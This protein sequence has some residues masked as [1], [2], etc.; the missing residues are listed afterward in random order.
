MK[1]VVLLMRKIS[2]FV[3]SMALLVGFA[4]PAM[5]AGNDQQKDLKKNEIKMDKELSIYQFDD[6]RIEKVKDYSKLSDQQKNKILLEMKFT[7]EDI[8]GMSSILKDQFLSIGGYKVDTSVKKTKIYTDKDGTNHEFTSNNG[9]E[10]NTL[11]NSETKQAQANSSEI[12][13]MSSVTDGIFS[14]NS[15][16]VF[17]GLTSNGAEYEYRMV[18]RYVWNGR[19]GVAFTDTIAHSYQSHST[20]YQTNMS[21]HTWASPS[22][23]ISNYQ[24]SMSYPSAYATFGDIDLLYVDGLQ[25]GYL[26]ES[27]RIPTRHYGETGAFAA[28]YAHPYSSSLVRAAL[29]SASISWDSTWGMKHNWLYYWTIGQ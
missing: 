21:R 27:V 25:E 8:A 15:W 20:R 13:T 14:A 16:V 17:Q 3:L 4:L 29:A 12:S 19:P 22:N 28:G 1:K 24:M 18:T 6:G 26:N 2:L 10:I 11:I 23:I 9:S 7:Q 5:A